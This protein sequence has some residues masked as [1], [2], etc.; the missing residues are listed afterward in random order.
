MQL[1]FADYLVVSPAPFVSVVRK[2]VLLNFLQQHPEAD[3]TYELSVPGDMYAT[4]SLLLSRDMSQAL[5]KYAIRDAK[6]RDEGHH[7]DASSG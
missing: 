3:L 1:G 5:L 7:E 2:D 4:P 6:G